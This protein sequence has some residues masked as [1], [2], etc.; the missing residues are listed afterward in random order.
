LN[1]FMKPRLSLIRL[2]LLSLVSAGCFQRVPM[3][4]AVPAPATRVVATLTDSGTVAMSNALG[5]GALEVE[6]VITNADGNQWTM[7]M[8][9]VDHRDQRTIEWNRELVTVPRNVITNPSV[10][11]FD[12]K[13]TWVAAAGI[14][15]GAFLAARAFNLVGGNDEINEGEQPQKSYVP[16]LSGSRK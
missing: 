5:A 8:L 1:H 16:I 13:R 9:R 11:V 4:A 7:Q 14:T 6:G 12:K 2:L 10:V 15:L 3:T